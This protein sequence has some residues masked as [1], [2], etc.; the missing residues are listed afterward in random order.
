[1]NLYQHS[2]KIGYAP[3]LLFGA[4][5]PLLLILALIYAYINVYNPIG[6]YI[7][8]LIILGYGFACGFAISILLKFGK[9]R[10]KMFCF[11][12]GLVGAFLSL[13]FAWS[14]FLYALVHRF[15]VADVGM[16]DII[17][18]PFAVWALINEINKTG[19]FTI[20]GGT[21]S[22]IF[23]WF[24]WGIEAVTILLIVTL[25]G[26][27][28]IDDE[29][30]CEKCGKWCDV[31]ETKHLKI[32]IEHAS[33][34]AS[35]INPLMLGNLEN[36]ESINARPVIKAEQLKCSNCINYSGWRY[37]IV[38]SEI[39]KDGNEKDKTDNISGIVMA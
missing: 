20:K 1:M 11:I 13:Y 27:S 21:P 5:I 12:G 6:G 26:S 29:M 25:I 4:G 22:G 9:T 37:K 36:A 17:L 38:S 7:T 28:A 8:F 15:G 10:S 32:P 33:S 24:L 14:F 30:F 39:D 18:N 16:L 35:A 23:L 2:G 31:S 34:K 19:W 3:I